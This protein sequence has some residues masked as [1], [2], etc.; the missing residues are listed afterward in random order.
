MMSMIYI[1]TF[2]LAGLY[3]GLILWYY[4]GWI[5]L[6]VF[7]RENGE[8]P[9]GTK[10]T[11]IIPARNEE[12]NIGAC[13]GAVLG[14]SYPSSLME[15]I[16][17]NDHSS[18]GTAAVVEAFSASNL[19][20]IHLADYLEGGKPLNAYKKKAIETAVGEAAGDLIITTDADC[21]MGREWVSTLAGFYEKKKMKFIAAP[22]AFHR[23]NNF[24]KVFQ[25]LDFMTMQG[26]TGAAARLKCGTMC[27]GANL[28]YEKKA[29]EEV[30]GFTGVDCIASG[31]DM[32]LMYK[33]YRAFPDR[34]GFLKNDKAI[35]STLAMS[36]VPEFMHQRIRWSSKAG[37]YD[38]K[39][40]TA[41]LALV[42]LWN[43]WLLVLFVIAL[44]RPFFWR[45]WIAALIFK[46]GVELFFL[47]PVARFFHKERLLWR[48]IPSQFLH[49]PYV[50]IAGWLGKF[51]SYRWKERKVQ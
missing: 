39:R 38:D 29:F 18:D 14:Q 25:S 33:M 43:A 17:V 23:E 8:A 24:F 34:I 6:P 46:T 51:G 37:K 9:P 27:N 7:D 49:I 41:V 31:D 22:V 40:L 4:Y 30:G 45:L 15:V 21:I 35:V 20:L 3:G 1:L 11:V 2:I 48:F 12:K 42:Y 13:L 19:K 16:V 44:F 32:L 36:T 47:L 50:I 10:V 28:A 5:T 26:I